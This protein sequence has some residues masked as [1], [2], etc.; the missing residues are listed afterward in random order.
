METLGGTM[1]KTV[2]PAYYALFWKNYK[3]ATDLYRYYLLLV[4]TV[5][6]SWNGL[7]KW[8]LLLVWT[9]MYQRICPKKK[10]LVIISK[11]NWWKN[12]LTCIRQELQ[13]NCNMTSLLLVTAKLSSYLTLLIKKHVSNS[14]H[15]RTVT[16]EYLLIN[17]WNSKLS[18]WGHH[19]A[20]HTRTLYRHHKTTWNSCTLLNLYWL[21]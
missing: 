8:Y 6:Y 3:L 17:C 16:T 1:L 14:D 13:C 5:M 19:C 18:R 2:V 20:R 21:L 15:Q 12:A 4:S 9:A 11:I 7:W 10:F